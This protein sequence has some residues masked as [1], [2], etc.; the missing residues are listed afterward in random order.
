MLTMS[1]LP[2]KLELIELVKAYKSR[3]Y[4]EEIVAIEA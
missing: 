4:D 1:F 2:A 3:L